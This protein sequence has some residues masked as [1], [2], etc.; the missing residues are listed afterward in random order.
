MVGQLRTLR[1]SSNALVA[2]VLIAASQ[3]GSTH[4][5]VVGSTCGPASPHCSGD[6]DEI[7]LLQRNVAQPALAVSPSVQA[8]AASASAATSGDV[9]WAL[10]GGGFKA[11]SMESGVLAGLLAFNKKSLAKN[12][13]TLS[14]VRG[15]VGTSG[16]AWFSAMLTYSQHFMDLIDNMAASPH[17]ASELYYD[18]FIDPMIASMAQQ[19]GWNLSSAKLWP[20]GLEIISELLFLGV[21][22]N[23]HDSLVSTVLEAGGISSNTPFGSES[24]NAWAKDRLFVVTTALATAG[25]TGPGNCE[26]SDTLGTCM[27]R[28]TGGKMRIWSGQNGPLTEMT[29]TSHTSEKLPSYVPTRFAIKVGAGLESP[30]ALP[31]CVGQSV[32]DNVATYEYSSSSKKATSPPMNYSVYTET[33]GM[34]PIQAISSAS[35]AFLGGFVTWAEP[36]ETKAWY[37]S[38]VDVVYGTLMDLGAIPAWESTESVKEAIKNLMATG[39]AVWGSNAQNGDAFAKGRE[40]YDRIKDAPEGPSLIDLDDIASQ[41]LHPIVDG[42]FV[43]N[44]GVL[45]AV[46]AGATEV[47]VFL[48][49]GVK[50]DF[51]TMFQGSNKTV[52]QVLTG[53]DDTCPFCLILFKIFAED[54]HDVLRQVETDFWNLT[55]TAKKTAFQI[56]TVSATTVDNLYWNVEAGRKVTLRVVTTFQKDLGMGGY[57]YSAFGNM[58]QELAEALQLQ[59]NRAAALALSGWLGMA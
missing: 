57:D 29:T 20:A 50:N 16:G 1:R 10:S 4:A 9:W 37:M 32:C 17:K 35:S 43:D 14:R 46:A 41:M 59:E 34:I 38:V 27:G 58:A 21:R 5:E 42:G 30:A 12:P 8:P 2:V 19:G 39:F 28:G 11:H 51:T 6:P 40:L 44:T 36:S 54:H 45:N 55:T 25:G 3:H 53:Y 26:Q 33:A 15:F 18:G 56:G 13:D 22:S 23:D 48:N 24:V 49:D 31:F 47:V 52:N 7:G